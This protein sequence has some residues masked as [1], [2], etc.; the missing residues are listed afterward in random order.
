M[1][2]CIISNIYPPFDRGGA[3]QVV[4][5]TVQGLRAKG[6][7]VVVITSTPEAASV[8]N[9]AG[10]RVY[11]FKPRN[12][13]FYTRAHRYPALVRI[14]WQFINML[15]LPVAMRVKHI[16]KKETP[17]VVH[18]HNLMGLSFLIPRAIRS[19]GIQHVHTVHDVQLVEPSGII[20]KE[21]EQS[22]RY[23]GIASRLYAGIVRRL[24]ASP[25]V[26]ISPS[27]FLLDFYKR[28]GF[29]VASHATVLRNPLTFS[30]QQESTQQTPT[31]VMT[32]MYVGQIESHK[33]VPLLIDAFMALPQQQV[34][35]HVVGSGS[36]LE[37]LKEKSASDPRIIMHGRL[38]RDEL[39][40]LFQDVDMTIVPSRCYENSPTVIFESFSFS[41]PVL[42]SDIEGVAELID[43]GMNGI[44]FETGDTQDLQEKINWVITH[45]GSIKDMKTKT[46]ESL[47]LL[48]EE[49]YI[50]KLIPLYRGDR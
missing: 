42:A 26:I 3:E 27:H 18:T 9:E 21:K 45:P 37:P 15:H 24:F 32:F 16:L 50:D 17:D 39:A 31:Q 22:R 1:K 4:V 34:Q 47:R 44:T 10:V 41:V 13:Y 46:K 11:R 7:E 43:E 33:G 6:H 29:F 30:L 20:L 38:E 8:K 25:N 12:L 2:I 5:K 40:T 14:L 19:L 28:R 35:L 48:M 49:D 23:T 36:L